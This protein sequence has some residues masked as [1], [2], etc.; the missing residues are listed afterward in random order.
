IVNAA[1]DV[2]LEYYDIDP[3][4]RL[5]LTIKRVA[6]QAVRYAT[7]G[8]I[9]GLYKAESSG[10]SGGYAQSRVPKVINTKDISINRKLKHYGPEYFDPVDIVYEK[11]WAEIF[12]QGS[13]G[14]EEGIPKNLIQGAATLKSGKLN[15]LELELSVVL[16]GVKGGY[17]EYLKQDSV[18]NEKQYRIPGMQPSYEKRAEELRRKREKNRERYNYGLIPK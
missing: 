5:G 12:Y 10:G 18:P 14:A 7:D 8:A 2:G 3:N 1:I 16:D 11:N 13:L 9:D 17:K 4:G 6:N 15:L